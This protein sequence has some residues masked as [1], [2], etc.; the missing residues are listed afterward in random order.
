MLDVLKRINCVQAVRMHLH[1]SEM[2][3]TT[4]ILTCVRLHF[5]TPCFLRNEH[6]RVDAGKIQRGACGFINFWAVFFWFWTRAH[7]LA[8]FRFLDAVEFD[9]DNSFASGSPCDEA[10][11]VLVM[12]KAFEM[13]SRQTTGAFPN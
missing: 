11:G 10:V 3:G 5:H 2:L 6:A 12:F 8:A 1:F 7:A 9:S 13:F 4:S